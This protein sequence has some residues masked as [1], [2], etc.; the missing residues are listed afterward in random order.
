MEKKLKSKIFILFRY[1]LTLAVIPTLIK[2]KTNV[3]AWILAIFMVL[4]LFSD[5]LKLLDIEFGLPISKKWFYR[6]Y[7]TLLAV[8]TIGFLIFLILHFRN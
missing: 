3:A 1:S 2:Y 5:A 6:L 4:V 7:Y 8:F